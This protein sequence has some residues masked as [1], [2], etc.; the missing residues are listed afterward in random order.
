MWSAVDGAQAA[1]SRA[2]IAA[3]NCSR[4]KHAA[5]FVSVDELIPFRGAFPITAGMASESLRGYHTSFLGI[6]L[7]GGHK[8]EALAAEFLL[9][10]MWG[11][12]KAITGLVHLFISREDF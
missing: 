10:R 6:C 5:L 8:A 2:D 3:H 12:E 1:A 11:R 4:W 7:E 9:C